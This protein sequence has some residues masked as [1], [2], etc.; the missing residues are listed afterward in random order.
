MSSRQAMRGLSAYG[1]SLIRGYDRPKREYALFHAAAGEFRTRCDAPGQ[2]NGD[3]W[4][5]LFS[6]FRLEEDASLWRL[7]L[8]SAVRHA[9]QSE[10]PRMGL[11]ALGYWIKSL[12]SGDIA[13]Y[14]GADTAAL[15]MEKRET[16]AALLAEKAAGPNNSLLQAA[17]LAYR[18]EAAAYRD[19]LAV[20][21]RYTEGGP[22]NH[23]NPETCQIGM[24][25]IK[26][27]KRMQEEAIEALEKKR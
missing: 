6:P 15:L 21:P 7:A 1:Y 25:A 20:F 27:A 13:Q 5:G 12:E 2:S 17:A 19:F 4:V 3:F 22:G 10:D 24:E 26:R 11:R 8:Q 16:A 23:S 14:A 18:E 9:R